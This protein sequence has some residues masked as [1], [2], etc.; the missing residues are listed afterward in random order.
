MLT[1][2]WSYR[3]PILQQRAPAELAAQLIEDALDKLETALPKYETITVVDF[4][5]GG[6]GPTPTIEKLVNWRRSRRGLKPIDFLMSDLHPHLDDWIESSQYSGH[7]SFIPQPVDASDPPMA[8]ISDRCRPSEGFSQ[9]SRIFRLYCLS[10]HHF[11]DDLAMKVLSSTMDTADGFAIVELQ[12]RR[13]FSLIL[14]ALQV[15]RLVHPSDSRDL[16]LAL[17]A[18]L[19]ETQPILQNILLFSYVN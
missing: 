6:G 11:D 16:V 3:V 13:I 15:S 10:F 14:M 17:L 12:D 4:C 18:E 9:D 5:S 1:A 7:L 8:A 19:Y 2:Q